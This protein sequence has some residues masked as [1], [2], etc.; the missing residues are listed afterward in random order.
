MFKSETGAKDRLGARR[1]FTMT[2]T[3]IAVAMAIL[4]S[5]A[6]MALVYLTARDVKNSLA[7]SRVQQGAGNLQDRL[8]RELRNMS[9]NE[10]MIFGD[11]LDLPGGGG[12]FQRVIVSRGQLYDLAEGKL[13]QQPKEEFF[14]EAGEHKLTHLLDRD[15]SGSA[16]VMFESTDNLILREMY[17][18]PSLNH[19][20]VPDF[21]L[22]NVYFEM[23]DNESGGKYVDGELVKIKTVRFFTVKM[24][25]R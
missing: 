7:V 10:S 24:R 12:A 18:Y 9:N 3:M 16:E 1:A 8:I 6:V 19:V 14:Y 25:N 17:F 15:D 2:E 23:D 5:S 21:T 22:L 20:N 11:Q 4:V 13:V